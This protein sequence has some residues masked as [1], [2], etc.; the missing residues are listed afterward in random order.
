MYYALVFYPQLGA[1]LA[2]SIDEIR[3]EYDPTW[4]LIK[5]HIDIAFPATKTLDQQLV[6]KHVGQVLTGWKPFAI[7]LSGFC[8][9]ED[10]WL[11]LLLENGADKIRILNQDV[12]TGYLAEYRKRPGQPGYNTVPHLAL[13]QFLKPG[14]RYDWRKPHASDFD[15]N[16]YAEA[17]PKAEALPLPADIL[18]DK[19]HLTVIPDIVT[20]WTTGKIARLPE[21]ARTTDIQEY[22]LVRGN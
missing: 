14:R 20:E 8:K 16:R 7:R 5:P 6:V 11:F 13:G 2:E 21:D 9:S 4:Q 15:E 22:Q 18:V 3:Q 10:H 17:L 1:E 12:Y 19:L